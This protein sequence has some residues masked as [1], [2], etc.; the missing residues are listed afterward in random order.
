MKLVGIVPPAGLSL[1]GLSPRGA[2]TMWLGR[3]AAAEWTA[4][5]RGPSVFL[6]APASFV[7][8][9][10]KPEEGTH[11]VYELARAQ[12][13]MLWDFAPG[14]K[15]ADAQNWTA[16]KQKPVEQKPA[17]SKPDDGDPGEKDPS[18]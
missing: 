11:R 2:M 15:A 6:H 9:E 17:D 5:V 3:G 14:E 4:E 8:G 10:V 13:Q 18:K 7:I 12:C 1:P 16:P